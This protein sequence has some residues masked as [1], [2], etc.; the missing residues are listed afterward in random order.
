[1]TG[2]RVLPADVARRIAAGEVI[3]RPVSAVKE[4]VENSLDAGARSVVVE[5]T[6][7]GQET[8][9]VV[10]DGEGIARADLPLAFQPHATSKIRSEEDLLRVSTLGFRGEA[11]ASIAAVADVEVW[12][13]R[14]NEPVGSRLR[15]RGGEVEGPFDEAAAVGCRIEV[16][17]LF[18][19]TPVRRKF[20]KS[21]AA[22]A[23]QIAQQLGRIA[24]GATETSFR[25]VQN[26]REVWSLARGATRARTRHVLGADVES[27]LSEVSVREGL[28]IEGFASHPRTSFAS[29]RNILWYVNGRW[30]R[31]RML[32]H[33]LIGAYAT[34]IP[35]G[36]FPAAV[37]FLTIEPGEVD[38][39][40]HPTKSEIRFRNPSVLYDAIRSAVRETFGRE[41][42]LRVGERIAAYM[43]R[44]EASPPQGRLRLAPAGRAAP[45]PEAS[46]PAAAEGPRPISR[47][48]GL[49][50]LGQVFD[51]YL[52]CQMEDSLVLVDQH[53]A[54]ERVA[55]E[56][57]RAEVRSGPP[58][59][60]PLLVPQT[61]ELAPGEAELV[62]E[63]AGTLA[64]VGVEV[65]PFGERAVIVRSVPAL[66]RGG[67]VAPLIRQVA[68]DLA[69][70]GR[71]RALEKRIE[72][73]LATIACHSVVRVGQRL[74][75][76][77]MQALLAS[78]DEIDWNTS[79]PH[80]RPVASILSRSELERRF[81]R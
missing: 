1:M 19:N 50:V 24:L 64:T 10:D 67:D 42:T 72:D 58:E 61:V 32:Q 73:L 49:R 65:E 22:E 47:H 77:E 51:G 8:I 6:R 63:A 17:D 37:L 55:F 46:P 34:L 71:S 38:V 76:A 20:L 57:L 23:G 40:V 78:M 66:F 80:G 21:P 5:T 53:A 62:A 25:L 48:S 26:G 43:E 2:I 75:E 35:H 9:A 31:D 44:H 30:V 56:R 79:C 7:G 52:V 18:Y 28:V 12:T 4:L 11:L 74:S 59:T 3:E 39:N 29:P 81:G 60:Q 27:S 68:A 14:R 45:E 41:A 69:E 33:A 13:R 36:R 70:Y 16:R 15:V 54:H